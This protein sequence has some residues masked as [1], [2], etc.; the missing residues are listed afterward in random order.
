MFRGCV[1]ALWSLAVLAALS[2]PANC[3]S[4]I[5]T[6]SGV[7][8]FFEGSVYLGDQPL[9]PHP[10][11]FTTVPKGAE[12]RTAEGRAELLLTPTVFL[13]V[14]EKS[15]IR[16]LRNELSNT[17]IELLAGSAIVDSAEPTRGT[18]VTLRY[19]NWSLRILEQGMYRIDADT[20][21]LW[22]LKGKVQVSGGI[23]QRGLSIEQGMHLRF[24][25]ALVPDRS[26][27]QPRDAFSTWVEGRQQAV[28]ADNAVVASTVDPASIP[29]PALV[30]Q[31]NS[32]NGFTV[33]LYAQ[34]AVAGVSAGF[35]AHAYFSTTP[36]H[37]SALLPSMRYGFTRLLS[38]APSHSARPNRIQAVGLLRPLSARV[39]FRLA[40]P[41]RPVSGVRFHG[42]MRR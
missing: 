37:S 13:R 32:G 18:S 23:D 31:A 36:R 21:R 15:A 40:V 3:Q 4:V 22:V 2:V 27:D 29:D 20:G 14:G 34:I 8:H 39:Q 42:G 35:I 5:S 26:V 30:S 12:L 17:Q 33:P 25:A 41:A 7:I 28:A 16:M 6:Y 9:V 1:G 11:K 10:G 38:D 24:A 19:R